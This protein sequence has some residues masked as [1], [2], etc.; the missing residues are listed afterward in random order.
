MFLLSLGRLDSF[1]GFLNT[2]E[3]LLLENISAVHMVMVQ[4]CRI[5]HRNQVGCVLSR[6][7]WRLTIKPGDACMGNQR[8]LAGLEN[9]NTN[10]ERNTTWPNICK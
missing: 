1:V 7:S 3:G 8:G 6:E 5:G 4:F 9:I 2:G 10:S